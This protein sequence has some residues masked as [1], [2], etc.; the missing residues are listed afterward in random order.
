MIGKQPAVTASW[1]PRPMAARLLFALAI[2]ALMHGCGRDHARIKVIDIK[3]TEVE[4]VTARHTAKPIRIAVGAVLTPKEGFGYYRQLL[5]YIGEKLQRPVEYVDKK[6]YAEINALLRDGAVDMAFV[7]SK[8]YV[9]GNRDFGLELLC[10]PQVNGGTVYHSYIIVPTDSTAKSLADL[11]GKTFAFSDPMSNSGKL[12]PT[13]MLSEIDQTPDSFFRKHIYSYAHDRTIQLVARQVVDG[14]AVDSIVWEC[15]NQL[16]DEHTARTRIIARSQP[17][18]IPPVV[19]PQRLDRQLK[20]N[21]KGILLNTHHDDQGRKI[22]KGM[23][24]DKF[25]EIDD[26]AYN[27]IRQMETSIARLGNAPE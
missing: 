7:C 3:K 5:D 9:D 8:P 2:A 22:L 13:F 16:N 17:F 25:V 26:S 23:M 1:H 19:V 10:A 18:G 27:S 11:K 15:E 20:A 21:L 4:S 24:L 14:G 12:A 6:T